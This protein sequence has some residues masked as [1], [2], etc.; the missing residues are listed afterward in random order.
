MRLEVTYHGESPNVTRQNTTAFRDGLYRALC[1]VSDGTLVA[2]V[3][4]EVVPLYEDRR[5]NTGLANVFGSLDTV[6]DVLVAAHAIKD[7]RDIVEVVVR[8]WAPSKAN[9]IQLLLSDGDEPF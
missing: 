3:L 1:A 9:G 4:L 7:K 6:F 2:P 8:S 5:S